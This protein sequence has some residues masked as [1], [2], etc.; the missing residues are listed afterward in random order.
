MSAT[1]PA[2]WAQMVSL[3]VGLYA[4]ASVPCFLLVDAECWAWPRPLTAAV[5]AARPVVWS[6]VRSEAV[7]PLL[8][9]FDNARHAS[10]EMAAEARLYA[11]LSLREA[12]LTAAAL[13]ALLTITQETT[14]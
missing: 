8:R 5:A 1:T 6:A 11:S 3:S 12:A 9:E 4:A 2:E 10:R 13:F 7:Y 14:S